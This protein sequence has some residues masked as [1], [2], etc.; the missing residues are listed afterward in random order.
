MENEKAKTGRPTDYDP[1]YCQELIDYFDV[2]HVTRKGKDIEPADFPQFTAFAKKIGVARSTLHKWSK[3]F[4][5]F[6]DAYNTARE[7]QE[8][9]LVNNGLKN[10]Y[11]PYFTQFILKNSHSYKDKTE[12]DQTISEVK[13]DRQDEIL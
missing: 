7:L 13:I 3:E 4:P 10:R 9:L 2:E 8:E 6:S 12:V 5:E 1:K 11:N